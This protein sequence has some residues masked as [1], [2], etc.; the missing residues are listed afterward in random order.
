MS[1]SLAF[2]GFDCIVPHNRATQQGL[3]EI[4]LLTG[5]LPQKL[6]TGI[7]EKTRCSFHA[8]LCSWNSKRVASTLHA[9]VSCQPLKRVCEW[10]CISVTRQYGPLIG[11][12]VAYLLMENARTDCLL[13]ARLFS[14][15]VALDCNRIFAWFKDQLSPYY[16][17]RR[18]CSKK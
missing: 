11:W 16:Q 6:A 18:R 5:T 14:F 12:P 17:C 13:L 4:E 15:R 8:C 2:R 3:L 7:L 10:L 1:L 9:M